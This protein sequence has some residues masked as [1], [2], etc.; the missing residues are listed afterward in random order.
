MA[1]SPIHNRLPPSR[2]D[3][4]F[5][6]H[7]PESGY[8]I[9]ETR[10]SLVYPSNE[11]FAFES[12]ESA[13]CATTTT[14]LYNDYPRH[15]PTAAVSTLVPSWAY[16]PSLVHHGLDFHSAYNWFPRTASGLHRPRCDRAS[17]LARAAFSMQWNMRT[18][19]SRL[20]SN[21]PSPVVSLTHALLPFLTY[22]IDIEL[23]SLQSSSCICAIYLVINLFY[24]AYTTP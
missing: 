18:R 10:S 4:H 5:G 3:Q 23:A 24:H 9:H 15:R 12:G 1:P 21:I 20:R 13:I 2:L 14:T 22:A 19:H 17:Y 11:V 16:I 8:R 6:L 7:L